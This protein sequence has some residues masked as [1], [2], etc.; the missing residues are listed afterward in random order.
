M[1][2]RL[3][4]LGMLM[5]GNTYAQIP[6]HTLPHFTFYR[7]DKSAFTNSDLLCGKMYF[8]LFFDSDCDHC[9]RAV[10][11]IDQQYQSFQ[12]TLI[13]LISVDDHDKI[14]RFVNTYA[15]H[16]KNK[17]NVVLLQDNLNQFIPRFKPYKYPSMYLYSTDK[18]LIDYENNEPTVFRIVHTIH[19]SL[20]IGYFMPAPGQTIHQFT[21]FRNKNRFLQ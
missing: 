6:A 19:A 8:F 18:K 20:L 9:Q 21:C 10:K 13:C 15:Q 11:N 7:H 3:A 1:S 5:A 2:I 12:N 17:K 4:I 16:L 14:D